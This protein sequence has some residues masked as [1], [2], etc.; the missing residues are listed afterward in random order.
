MA[1]KEIE[2]ENDIELLVHAFYDKVR[3]DDLLFPVFDDIIK[4]NWPA[5]LQKMVS[6]WSTLLLY[7]RTYEGDPLTTHIPLPLTFQHFERW[8]HLFG[9]TVDARFTGQVAE[10]AKKRA[11]SIAR[12]MK[13]VKDIKE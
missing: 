5:H 9:E 10:N 4:D 8:L 2:T 7:T 1:T 13:A 6:F 11:S 3:N 12:I